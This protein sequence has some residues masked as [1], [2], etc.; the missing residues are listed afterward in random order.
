[1]RIMSITFPFRSFLALAAV[2]LG[3]SLG[4][5]ADVPAL[6]NYQGK[7]TDGSG[8]T[9]AS[10]TY[11]MQFRIWNDSSGDDEATNLVW[12]EDTIVYVNSD[13]TFNV[14]L[15]QGVLLGSTQVSSL[16]ETFT[17]EERYLGLTVTT[18]EN[19]NSLASEDI[20]ELTPRQQFLS[21][22]FAVQ[23]QYAELATDAVR[24]TDADNADSLGNNPASAYALQ[25][26][27]IIPGL[28]SVDAGIEFPE[29]ANGS[30]TAS[31]RYFD[32]SGASPYD[33][34]LRLETTGEE[35]DDIVLD[36]AG[37]VELVSGAL[38]ILVDGNN[39]ELTLT[40][41]SAT[42]SISSDTAINLTGGALT[43]NAA[44]GAMSLQTGSDDIAIEAGSG[45]DV[46]IAS[47]NQLVELTDYSQSYEATVTV[48]AED[49]LYLYAGPAAQYLHTHGTSGDDVAIAAADDVFVEASDNMLLY[50]GLD[51]SGTIKMTSPRLELDADQVWTD[52]GS[53]FVIEQYTPSGNMD[54][55]Y[56]TA[57]WTAVIVGFDSDGSSSMRRARMVENGDVWRISWN[58]SGSGAGSV[59]VMYIRKA[60]ITDNR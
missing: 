43:L 1:M 24:A 57:D 4:Q 48:L 25:E 30:D 44:G 58:D 49:D 59:D 18:D 60:W 37:A 56:S 40:G 20:A 13:G 35:G 38:S 34:I 31:I 12:G 22:G 36:A 53:V 19:T 28:G 15:G 45:G 23:A 41:E 14:I 21:T 42:V 55:G 8:G 7:L 27:A 11:G 17:G 33:N 32:N 5:A 46:R 2:L 50:A 29:S 9:A 16:R 26:Q 52:S 39:D 51:G 6:I 54:T 3:S 10:G 47:N